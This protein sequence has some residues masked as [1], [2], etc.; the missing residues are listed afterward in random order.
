MPSHPAHHFPNAGRT[1]Q[2]DRMSADPS[3]PLRALG[4]VSPGLSGRPRAGTMP[5]FT[6]GTP[7]E[8]SG[9]SLRVPPGSAAVAQRHLAHLNPGYPATGSLS[10][11]VS[12][13]NT[14][15]PD[16]GPTNYFSSSSNHVPHA[17]P[18]PSASV[19][20]FAALRA[21]ARAGTV[22]LPVSDS[23]SSFGGG[24]AVYSSNFS[25]WSPSSPGMPVEQQGKST[26]SVLSGDENPEGAEHVR[27]LISHLGLDTDSPISPPSVHATLPA[28]PQSVQMASFRSHNGIRSAGTNELIAHLNPMA[29]RLRASTV[30]GMLP[31]QMPPMIR[32]NSPLNP[33]AVDQLEGPLDGGDTSP[34]V[35]RGRLGGLPMEPGVSADAR[36]LY[37][38]SSGSASASRAAS[39]EHSP[40]RLLSHTLAAAA[41]ARPRAST[42]AGAG[43]FAG[44][45]PRGSPSG[46]LNSLNAA[47]TARARAGTLA[48]MT[49]HPNL[50]G[51]ATGQN[52][53]SGHVGASFS[54]PER[55]NGLSATALGFVPAAVEVR[56]DTFMIG[57]LF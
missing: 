22:G 39:V 6:L 1:G 34:F 51:L 31:P 13:G 7:T 21:R 50:L 36:L 11:P 41:L 28:H 55:G 43:L 17:G 18:K 46:A 2:S 10:L 19:S 42:M 4:V 53:S 30:S 25:P 35:G 56:A 5:S 37:S 3:P 45:S 48:S 33:G 38:S 32:R 16:A 23:S 9:A 15:N 40:E 52:G 20:D 8:G 24:K 44:S 57:T 27:D 47:A 54:T 29:G 26:E 12:G 14:P 49:S